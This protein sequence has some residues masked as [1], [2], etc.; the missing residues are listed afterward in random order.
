M[1]ELWVTTV[2]YCIVGK[3][4]TPNKLF[5]VRLSS[6]LPTLLL[7]P[8]ELESCLAAH[9]QVKECIVWKEKDGDKGKKGGLRVAAVVNDAR[10][11]EEVRGVVVVVAAAAVATCVFGAHL[12]QVARRAICRLG[13]DYLFSLLRDDGSILAEESVR[14]LDPSSVHLIRRPLPRNKLGKLMRADFLAKWGG[15]GKRTFT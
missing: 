8:L 14:M 9:P 15:E 3:N 7:H 10:D 2:L 6:S 11:D 13:N 4:T 1:F 5:R 12:L